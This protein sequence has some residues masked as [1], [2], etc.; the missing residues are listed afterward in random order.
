MLSK[1]VL[2]GS[3]LALVVGSVILPIFGTSRAVSAQTPND[4]NTRA[5][6]IL[7]QNCGNSGCHGGSDPYSFDVREPASLLAA[8]VVEVGNA[9]GS[10]LIGR[11]EAGVMPMGG[12]KGQAGVKLPSEYIQTLK[13][14]IDAGG[15]QSAS[16]PKNVQRQFIPESQVLAAITRDLESARSADRP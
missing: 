13:Q 11:L 4:L 12:Y 8:K 10:D 1:S 15:P 2:F 16:R 14:W 5:L 9:A 6:T 3:C 7:Q